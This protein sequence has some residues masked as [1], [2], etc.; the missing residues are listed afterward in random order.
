VFIRKFIYELF[1]LIGNVV[2]LHTGWG[3]HMQKSTDLDS[4]F[5]YFRGQGKKTDLTV[6]NQSGQA[7]N[8]LGKDSRGSIAGCLVRAEGMSHTDWLQASCRF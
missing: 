2:H 7:D 3:N 5:T 4:L 6:S 8:Q 1:T